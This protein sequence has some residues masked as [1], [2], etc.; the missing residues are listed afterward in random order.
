MVLG[1]ECLP[2]KDLEEKRVSSEG[3]GVAA[4]SRRNVLAERE[5]STTA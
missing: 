1:L 5:M 4:N 3:Q 2:H